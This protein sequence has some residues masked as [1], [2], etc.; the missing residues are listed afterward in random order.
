MLVLVAEYLAQDSEGLCNGG[1]LLQY[2]PLAS[3][4]ASLAGLLTGV[5][6]VGSPSSQCR[7]G[8]SANVQCAQILS[9]LS[10]MLHSWTSFKEAVG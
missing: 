3:G 5:F 10:F 4:L 2:E 7:F 1:R 8:L 9:I 6:G